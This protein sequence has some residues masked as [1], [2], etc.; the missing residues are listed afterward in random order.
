MSE[1]RPEIIRA[2]GRFLTKKHEVLRTGNMDEQ[3]FYDYGETE[4]RSSSRKAREIILRSPPVFLTIPSSKLQVFGEV[5]QFLE[6]LRH[7]P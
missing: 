6:K 4:K 5:A 3:S 2:L 1:L 7:L